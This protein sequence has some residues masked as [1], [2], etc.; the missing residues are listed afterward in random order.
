MLAGH[1]SFL[2]SRFGLAQAARRFTPTAS[3]SAA[4]RSTFVSG[5]ARRLT[6]A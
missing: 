6:A 3:A 4:A 1:V 5:R 2:L